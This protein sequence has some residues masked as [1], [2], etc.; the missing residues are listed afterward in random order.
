MIFSIENLCFLR[1]RSFLQR[2]RAL[3]KIL[4]LAQNSNLIEEFF[5]GDQKVLKQKPFLSAIIIWPIFLRKSQIFYKLH[6]WF[7][8]IYLSALYIPQN[9]LLES[10]TL[11]IFKHDYS[12]YKYHNVKNEK[13]VSLCVSEA[14]NYLSTRA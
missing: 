13:W 11:F 4:Y 2:G 12:K 7:K 14:Y 1:V 6:L 10:G 9:S 8:L 3:M 5:F